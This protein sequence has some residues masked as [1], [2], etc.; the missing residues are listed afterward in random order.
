[1]CSICLSQQ[2]KKEKKASGFLPDVESEYKQSLNHSPVQKKNEL[3]H[4]DGGPTNADL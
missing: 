2:T 1:M 3:F 4:L